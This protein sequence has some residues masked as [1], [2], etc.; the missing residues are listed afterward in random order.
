MRFNML[1][2][3]LAARDSND[4]YL[5]YPFLVRSWTGEGAARAIKY[6]DKVVNFKQTYVI[7][8]F[9]YAEEMREYQC[10][11][12]KLMEDLA[13]PSVL[14]SNT[15]LS[16]LF[17]RGLDSAQQAYILQTVFSTVDRVKDLPD[18]EALIHQVQG[19]DQNSS[20]EQYQEDGV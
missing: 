11:F 17:L 15:L 13:A 2:G 18:P 16:L 12:L 6:L 14:N 1:P 19:F 20:H 7:S 10:T 9:Q 4:P 3:A 5:L 8:H